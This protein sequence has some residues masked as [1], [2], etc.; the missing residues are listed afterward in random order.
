MNTDSFVLV[1]LITF[2]LS[3]EIDDTCMS[4][5]A[6][7]INVCDTYNVAIQNVFY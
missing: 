5:V 6:F 2:S 4:V 1:I 3:H 7:Y